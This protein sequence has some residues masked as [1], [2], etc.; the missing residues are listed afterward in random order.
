[1]PALNAVISGVEPGENLT[2]DAK[3]NSFIADDEHEE[4][5][6]GGHRL[7][8]RTP[9]ERWVQR[10]RLLAHVDLSSRAPLDHLA[11]DDF[12][13]RFRIQYQVL[14]RIAAGIGN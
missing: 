2:I 5:E 8:A 11:D 12:Q 1:G 6:I 3:I 9:D 7:A 4:R 10:V 13:R 14:E